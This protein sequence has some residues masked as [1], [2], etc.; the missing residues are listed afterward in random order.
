MTI[1]KAFALFKRIKIAKNCDRLRL[2][3]IREC[4]YFDVVNESKATLS[5]EKVL[6]ESVGI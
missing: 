6:Q 2:V 5:V 3:K 1:V 4:E